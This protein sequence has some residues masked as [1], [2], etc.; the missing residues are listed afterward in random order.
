MLVSF[1]GKCESKNYFM[2]YDEYERDFF[3][4]AH[5]KQKLTSKETTVIKNYETLLDVFAMLNS[6]EM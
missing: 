3:T 2:F 6:D 4:K 1:V 5:V